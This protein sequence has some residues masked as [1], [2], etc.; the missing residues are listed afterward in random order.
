VDTKEIEVI[1]KDRGNFYWY[2]LQHLWTSFPIVGLI[3][4]IIRY[5]PFTGFTFDALDS[6]RLFAEEKAL[7]VSEYQHSMGKESLLEGSS[8]FGPRRVYGGPTESRKSQSKLVFNNNR[9]LIQYLCVWP[10]AWET[11][12]GISSGSSHDGKVCSSID[13]V[14]H[15]KMYAEVGAILLNA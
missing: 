10:Y 11:G 9:G 13:L 1:V 4:A 3:R 5:F 15:A 7:R 12:P 6:S 14:H 8:S 2:G